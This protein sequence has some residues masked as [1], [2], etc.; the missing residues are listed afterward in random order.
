LK[1]KKYYKV[2]GSNPLRKH[3]LLVS[4]EGREAL[5]KPILYPPAE[6]TVSPSKQQQQL[7]FAAPLPAR[8]KTQQKIVHSHPFAQSSRSQAFPES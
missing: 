6:F 7:T 1:K 5:F 3:A 8:R 4:A 2:A